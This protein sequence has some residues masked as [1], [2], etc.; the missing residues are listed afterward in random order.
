MSAE[1][2]GILYAQATGREQPYTRRRIEQMERKDD[3]PQDEA[4]HWALAKIVQLGVSF[5]LSSLH[6]PIELSEV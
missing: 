6:I 2:L 4:R 1:E 3:F 5:S